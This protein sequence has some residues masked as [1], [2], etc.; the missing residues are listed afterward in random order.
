MG[1]TDATVSS[2][3]QMILSPWFREALRYDPQAK[4]K[5]VKCPVLA[6]NGERDIQVA[7][8]VNPPAIRK[9]LAALED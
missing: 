5:A 3:I 7:A 8:K 1:S 6:I 2:Q 9:A 4:L